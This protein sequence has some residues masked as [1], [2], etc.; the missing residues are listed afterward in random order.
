[1][2]EVNY[3]EVVMDESFDPYLPGAMDVFSEAVIT[4]MREFA[5]VE[6]IGLDVAVDR[7]IITNKNGNKNTLR[8]IIELDF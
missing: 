4:S 5:R 7:V 6:N 3:M 8:E 1:M 2:E